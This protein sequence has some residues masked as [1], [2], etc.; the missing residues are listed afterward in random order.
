MDLAP[1]PQLLETPDMGVIINPYRHGGGVA[2]TLP[3]ANLAARW[4]ADYRVEKDSSGNP[5]ADGDA[6]YRW[7]SDNDAHVVTGTHPINRPVF[8]AGILNGL[9]GVDF[10]GVDRYLHNSVA[11]VYSGPYY[12]VTLYAVVRSRA[13]YGVVFWHGVQ[14]TNN[15]SHHIGSSGAAAWAW[16]R[17]AAGNLQ[18]AIS[19]ETFT[20]D[21]PAILTVLE[22]G[23][24]RTAWTNN[25]GPTTNSNPVTGV[26]ADSFAIGKQYDPSP[27][28]DMDGY[29]FEVLVY[30]AAHDAA[31]RTQV[32]DYLRDKWGL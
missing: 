25:T 17:D 10:D 16:A 12:P 23:T 15:I 5:C 19:T 7:Y 28:G 20:L 14:S 21:T 31:T 6:V 22:E 3:T 32:Y 26:T 2:P 1:R 4:R 30:T 27:T 11:V 29:V 13:T 8:R 24:S 9:P 18:T